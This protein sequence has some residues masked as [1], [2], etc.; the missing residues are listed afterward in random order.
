MS[1]KSAN[2]LPTNQK[3]AERTREKK[4]KHELPI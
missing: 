4:I 3:N 1:Q 2:K